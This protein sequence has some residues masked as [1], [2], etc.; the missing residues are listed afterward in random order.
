MSESNPENAPL[1][2]AALTPE[3]VLRCTETLQRIITDRA[4]LA[5]L[6]EE[7]RR[8]LL[9]AAGQVS[10]P[11]TRQK[12]QLVKE[13]RRK[14]SREKQDQDRIAKNSA[15]I[16]VA[17]QAPVFT[18]PAPTALPGPSSISAAPAPNTDTWPEL[19][20]PHYCYICK[21]EYRRVHPF[22]DSMCPPCAEFN[23]LKRHQ[24]FDL[25]GM[26]ALVTGGRVKIG[27]H[28]ALKLLRAG[29]RVLVTTRFPRDG[30][31]RFAKEEDYAQWR[32]R[33][34]LFGLDLRHSPSVELFA[35]YILRTETRLD[36]LI[37]NA[38]QTVRRPPDFYRPL[39]ETE[40][41]PFASLPAEYRALVAAHE[42]LKAALGGK[43]TPRELRG[44][45]SARPDLTGLS[46]WH[47]ANGAN[48]AGA[49]L[50]LRFSAQLST[51]PYAYGDEMRRPDLFPEGKTDA[52]LQQ[53]DLRAVN[54]W[55]LALED[56]P[57]PELLE[58]HLV[59]AVAPFI[60]NARLK[61]LMLRSP[62]P[63]R[64]IVNVSAMEGIFARGTKTDKHPH[65]NMAKAALNMLTY[66]SARGYAPDGIYMN[67]VDTGWVTDEDPM[68]H[69]KRKIAEHDFS[70]PLDIVDG[71]ARILDPVFSG[72]IT[73]EHVFGKF[74]KDYK[75]ANW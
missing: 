49:G 26:T 70:P 9:I 67:A 28:T 16:R 33:L 6:P 73:G 31:A 27:Y 4:L 17:R 50:G 15:G 42:D 66:T 61:G 53:V 23:Y 24:S 54:S 47:G 71:A 8:E 2:S 68:H 34:Q 22:Y 30:A 64:H 21:V 7:L 63:A 48:Q 18:A 55:R 58:V 41:A 29:A 65:T 35:R 69:A 43:E 59:N 62:N 10:R 51:V 5:Q 52:D 39:I 74:F 40:S 46:A 72:F 25:T 11:E 12:K 13:F 3:E 75:A 45:A 37:N 19:A 57:T 56:V 1:P 32:E 36:V 38:C 14:R 60:L 20:R 44:E